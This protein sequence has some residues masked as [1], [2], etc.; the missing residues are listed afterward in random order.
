MSGTC[1]A[2]RHG[3]AKAYNRGCR[4]PDA[5]ADATRRRTLHLLATGDGTRPRRIDATGSRRRIRA[6][7]ADGWPREIIAD[8]LGISLSALDYYS[9]RDRVLAAT[10]E[11]I[12]AV[13][14]NLADTSGPSNSARA[15]ARARGWLS[16]IWWDDDLIDDPNYDP[17]Q[18][19]VPEE[20]V[21]Y[22][23]QMHPSIDPIA[24]DRFVHGDTTVPLNRDE[25]RCAYKEMLS[26][27]VSRNEVVRRLRISWTTAREFADE[28]EKLSVVGSSVDD[29]SEAAS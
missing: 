28:A 17:Q 21:A 19:L 23:W 25:K 3:N 27:G 14:Q 13:Y 9:R 12:R 15:Q 5:R 4:C 1:T 22:P 6:L 29:M 2:E 11:K 18:R 26:R 10:A 20:N 7:I 24:V 8:E 16:P